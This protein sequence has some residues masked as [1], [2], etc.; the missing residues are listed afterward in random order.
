M[1][2]SSLLDNKWWLQFQPEFHKKMNLGCKHLNDSKSDSTEVDVQ[3]ESISCSCLVPD[4]HGYGHDRSNSS[5]PPFMNSKVAELSNVETV[6]PYQTNTLHPLKVNEDKLALKVPKEIA[7]NNY[8]RASDADISQHCQDVDSTQYK[9]MDSTGFEGSVNHYLDCTTAKSIDK[10][11]I[12]WRRADER[13]LA[14]IVAIKSAGHLQ[15][16][17][18]PPPQSVSWGRRG[19]FKSYGEYEEI[20]V[21]K[22]PDRGVSVSSERSEI[23]HHEDIALHSMLVYGRSPLSS[24][25]SQTNELPNALRSSSASSQERTRKRSSYGG[26][27]AIENNYE[28]SDLLEALRHSQT[29]AREAEKIATLVFSEKEKLLSL[30]FREAS[31][32]FAYRQW[33]R[34]LEI[35]TRQLKSQSRGFPLKYCNDQSFHPHKISIKK[36]LVMEQDNYFSVKCHDR[37]LNKGQKSDPQNSGFWC[38]AVTLGISLASA[39]LILGWSTG[40]VFPSL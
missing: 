22:S 13:E 20:D 39:G 31:H 32:L 40:W 25:V 9:L 11:G 3:S 30:L 23:T 7:I 27:E 12:T 38:L 34:L 33:L 24:A 5:V 4:Q 8:S 1:T 15:N 19:P 14:S 6:G 10:V 18:L 17:D 26:M 36:K 35:E 16:C 2:P 28:K 37:W 29:R 21:S